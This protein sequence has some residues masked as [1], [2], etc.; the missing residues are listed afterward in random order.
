MGLPTETKTDKTVLY[1]TKIGEHGHNT[2]SRQCQKSCEISGVQKIIQK[3]WAACGVERK[4]RKEKW[5]LER[6]YAWEGTIWY[7]KLHFES[8]SRKWLYFSNNKKEEKTIF[9]RKKERH[10]A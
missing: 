3:G 4:M 7:M 6:E 10:D 2:R 8:A 9:K 1:M 5:A